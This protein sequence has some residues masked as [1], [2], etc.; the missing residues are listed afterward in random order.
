[1]RFELKFLKPPREVVAA[2]RDLL[3]NCMPVRYGAEQGV[4]QNPSGRKAG[5]RGLLEHLG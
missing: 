4:L 2:C 3:L 1:M 5:Y